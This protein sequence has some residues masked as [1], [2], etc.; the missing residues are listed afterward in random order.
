MKN[1]NVKIMG[2]QEISHSEKVKTAGGVNV[3]WPVVGP[4]I[5]ILVPTIVSS[6]DNNTNTESGTNNEENKE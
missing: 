1:L 4:L 5:G 3:L 6:G 2:L